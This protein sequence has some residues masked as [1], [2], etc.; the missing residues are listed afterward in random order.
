MQNLPFFV[1]EWALQRTLFMIMIV[2]IACVQICWVPILAIESRIEFG[3]F[4]FRCSYFRPKSVVEPMFI[5][6]DQTELTAVGP[7]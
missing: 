6:N 7:T 3:E 4:L 2:F 5:I 1:G